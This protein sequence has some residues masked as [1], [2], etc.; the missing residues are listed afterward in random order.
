MARS[1]YKTYLMKGTS[2]NTNT[3]TYT[4]LVDIKEFPDLG[5]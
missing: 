3:V 1:T 5:A 4:K 2:T